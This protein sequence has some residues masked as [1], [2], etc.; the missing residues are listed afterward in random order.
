LAQ[1]GNSETVILSTDAAQ[2]KNCRSQFQDLV[3]KESKI[4]LSKTTNKL[5]I[6]FISQRHLM[7]V[8]IH[9]LNKLV[10]SQTTIG[11]RDVTRQETLNGEKTMGEVAGQ[12]DK[13]AR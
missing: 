10:T 5:F 1:F 4:M 12:F 11:N 9:H 7:N 8:T 3:K 6:Y 13:V 2:A